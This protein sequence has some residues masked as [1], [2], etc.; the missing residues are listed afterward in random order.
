MERREKKREIYIKKKQLKQRLKTIFY[1]IKNDRISCCWLD[2]TKIEKC[3]KMETLLKRLYWMEKVTK[4]QKSV[5][6]T[7]FGKK[8]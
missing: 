5:R 7:R 8:Q 1:L 6:E 2:G 4:T 3:E